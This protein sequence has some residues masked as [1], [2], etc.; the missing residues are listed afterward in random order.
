MGMLTGTTAVQLE[1]PCQAQM[2]VTLMFKMAMKYETD[3]LV[4]GASSCGARTVQAV[5][6]VLLNTYSRLLVLQM[7]GCTISGRISRS[8]CSTSD[9]FI[10]FLYE[11]KKDRIDTTNVARHEQPDS[12]SCREL[13]LQEERRVCVLNTARGFTS[14]HLA[15]PGHI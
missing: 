15:L 3:C 12:C 5:T 13:C 2:T 9:D 7:T 4:L 8:S 11:Y 14:P 6:A 1:K 10:C